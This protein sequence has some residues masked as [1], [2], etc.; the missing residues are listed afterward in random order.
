VHV[1]VNNGN[2]AATREE[3]PE[4]IEV[5]F[6]TNVLGY[7]WVTRQIHD[8]LDALRLE[9][10]QR[11]QLLGGRLAAPD[12]QFMQRR[13]NNDTAYRQSKQADRMLTV[14][15]SD[16]LA[17]TDIRQRVPSR[18]RHSRL[19]NDLGFGGSESPIRCANSVWLATHDF[20]HR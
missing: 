20:G 3:T 12:L 15:L 18:R 1:L 11:R 4:G 8:N 19:S 13:Y 17:P 6:A 5:Q 10:G 14:A 7:L 9:G 2:G 16:R